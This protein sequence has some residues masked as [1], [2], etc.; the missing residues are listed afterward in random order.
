MSVSRARDRVY[1]QP[2]RALVMCVFV[3][4]ACGPSTG[5]DDVDPAAPCTPQDTASCY[6]GQTGTKDVGPCHGGTRTCDATGAWSA[7]TDEVVPVA[8]SCADGIDNNCNGIT[9]E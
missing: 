4:V 8:E 9:D 5:D 2:M 6:S 7:C 3:L 1:S